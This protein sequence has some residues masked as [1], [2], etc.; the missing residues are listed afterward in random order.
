M[1]RFFQIAC[2]LNSCVQ[3]LASSAVLS[4]E[5]WTPPPA[6]SPTVSTHESTTRSIRDDLDGLFDELEP[7]FRPLTR[8]LHR[9][10]RISSRC[11]L[12][13]LKTAFALRSG[14]IWA[15]KLVTATGFQSNGPFEG[16]FVN[17]GSQEQCLNVEGPS[18]L[19]GRYCTLFWR[20]PTELLLRGISE[21]TLREKPR[22]DIRRW[23]NNTRLIVRVGGRLG[24]CVPSACQQ[25]EM[26]TIASTV[27][28]AYGA[29][30]SVEYCQVKEP[31]RLGKLEVGIIS[32]FGAVLV[33]I[34]L[35]TC[36][37]IVLSKSD[38][39]EA[40]KRPPALWRKLAV[41]YSAVYN[42]KKLLDLRVV[43]ADS[44]R[45]RFLHGMKF[46]SALWVVLG[47]TYF[48]TQADAIDS[49]FRAVR[50][51]EAFHFQVV[52][53]GFLCV[54]TFFF[55]SGFLLGYTLFQKRDSLRKKNAF[56]QSTIVTARRYFRT[57]IPAMVVVSALFLLP[58]ILHGPLAEQNLS[59]Q[60]HGCS[61]NWW[62]V[63]VHINNFNKF[64]D[65]CLDHFWYISADMQIFLVGAA[66][67]VLMTRHMKVGA[68]LLVLLSII[69]SG[70]V[71][72]QTFLYNYQPTMLFFNPDTDKTTETGE[73]VYAR[74]FVHFG[75]FA[76]GIFCS[77]CTLSSDKWHLSK[78]R[79]WA[80]WALS[81]SCMPLVL[82]ASWPWNNM[83]LPSRGMA[84]MY[85]ALHKNAWALCIAWITFACATG[86][87]GPVNTFLSW[88]GFVVPSRLT[89]S[90][91]LIHYLVY[92]AR[93]GTVN[94]PMQQHEFLQFKDFL[95]VSVISYL[96]A[97][98]LYLAA[99]APVSN[100][101]KMLLSSPSPGS[102][103]GAA[104]PV[105]VA[106]AGNDQSATPGG[107]AKPVT[108]CE[109]LS[110][111]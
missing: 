27:A 82:F 59:R 64:E 68:V 40:K 62:T 93:A 69:T 39:K 72:A 101:E 66:L 15:L 70:I 57:T 107:A 76:I 21:A 6:V 94:M 29:V 88:R 17:L 23:L 1:K 11:K 43:S 3:W 52:A 7:R 80:L 41:T 83:R 89:Y 65:M 84:A 42:T 104:V 30:A 26:N 35:S 55:V 19:R 50:L 8:Y 102:D 25:K 13:L 61:K 44:Q 53:N 54:T 47:H 9:D 103:R 92:M 85:A 12:S 14:D 74:P 81:L 60:Y 4:T 79:R 58:K 78:W 36:A 90:V 111:L 28:S 97:Y 38:R 31:V 73:N 91:Y 95:G 37:D 96:L 87:A 105:A 20:P 100:L 71:L 75:P 110:K 24:I 108:T 56:V 5:P 16:G 109:Q 46:L 106:R 10:P 51:M 49:T 67:C 34:I 33:M 45:L 48:T 18:G 99:E 98:L 86:Q 22:L 77:L 2:L 63:L 32:F